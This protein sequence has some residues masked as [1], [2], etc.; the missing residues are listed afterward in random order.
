MTPCPGPCL[1]MVAREHALVGV[2][3][4][5]SGGCAGVSGL[6]REV[7]SGLRGE[8][9]LQL[10][11][12]R[13]GIP[14]HHYRRERAEAFADWLRRLEADLLVTCKAPLLPAS[15]FTLP[16]HGAINIHYSL[17]PA[18]R[19]GSPLLWQVVSGETRG[20]VTIH[21]IDAGIDTGPVL[22]Q[23][24][25]PLPRGATAA[26]LERLLGKLA[27]TL[28]ADALAAVAAGERGVTP[29]R[30]TNE[31]VF[32]HNIAQASLVDFIDWDDWPLEKIWRV[33]RFMAFWP[34][35]YGI[36]PGWPRLMRWRV[37]GIVSRD[38]VLPAG[39]WRIDAPGCRLLLRTRRGTIEL[40]P[41]LH[42]PTLLRGWRG[43]R[44][45]LRCG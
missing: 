42:P 36:P 44:R 41:S 21:Y 30:P 20:G 19:G 23:A 40:M 25:L 32:A 31:M 7:W 22:R 1:R 14:L 24:P 18:Y 8:P 17:L 2:A 11:A 12:A 3:T 43:L 37:G 33:L 9:S 29:A 6:L 34:A 39:G 27:A 38:A 28:L 5:D 26:Q 16:R 35:G 45:P 10:W 15:V 4:D 13:R